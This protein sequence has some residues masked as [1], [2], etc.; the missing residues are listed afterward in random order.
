M[1]QYEEFLRPMIIEIPGRNRLE[2]D[3]PIKDIVRK[4][5][6]INIER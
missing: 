6:G 1:P 5:I 4:A 2:K 3:D